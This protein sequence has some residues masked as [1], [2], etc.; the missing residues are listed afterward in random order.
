MLRQF[1]PHICAGTFIYFDEMNHVEDEPKAFDELMRDTGLKF[2]PVSADRT[3]E[4]V[5]FECIG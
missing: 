5:F 1:A 4:R 2:R 3:L